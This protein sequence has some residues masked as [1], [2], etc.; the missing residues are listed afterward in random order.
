MTQRAEGIRVVERIDMPNLI[1]LCG[2]GGQ[3]RGGLFTDR[4]KSYRTFL[5]VL[6]LCIRSKLRQALT[7]LFSVF[8]FEILQS[9]NLFKQMRTRLIKMKVLASNLVP[10]GRSC[11]GLQCCGCE[12]LVMQRWNDIRGPVS[13][14]RAGPR[15]T[16]SQ[17][18]HLLHS[19][20]CPQ[21]NPIKHPRHRTM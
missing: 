9:K 15:A 1:K 18:V 11:C 5:N 8:V 2:A 3:G 20:Y 14:L 19:H 12:R 16:T 17:R 10:C 21:T 6:L 7:L 13:C 4:V